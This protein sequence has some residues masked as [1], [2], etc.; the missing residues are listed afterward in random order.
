MTK[1]SEIPPGFFFNLLHA[2]ML[3]N[4]TVAIWLKAVPHWEIRKSLS[5]PTLPLLMLA[6]DYIPLPHKSV[7]NDEFIHESQ[8]NDLVLTC[9]AG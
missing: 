6:S 2:L 9:R 7:D 8:R 3:V 4:I 5:L 1:P